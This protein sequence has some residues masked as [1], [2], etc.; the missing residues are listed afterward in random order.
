MTWYGIIGLIAALC[1][2]IYSLPQLIKIIK[3]KDTTGISMLMFIVMFL[4]DLFFILNAIGILADNNGTALQTKLSSG[5][6]ILIANFISICFCYCILLLKIRNMIW[7]KRLNLS[8][9]NFCENYQKNKEK[10]IKIKRNKI[11]EELNNI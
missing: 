4:G 9:K 2:A 5:L 10:I 8:E 3:T 11:N 6:P 7:S 1:I